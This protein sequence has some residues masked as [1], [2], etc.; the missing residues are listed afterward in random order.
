MIIWGVVVVAF[1]FNPRAR[2]ERDT[3]EGE[4]SVSCDVSIHALAWS[5]TWEKPRYSG[6][7]YVSIHALAWS[8]T[9]S[10][11]I[12]EQAAKVSIHALAWSATKE[13]PFNGTK[14]DVSIHA[15]AWSATV[16][17]CVPISFVMFQ[18]TR[19]HGAR[20]G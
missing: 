13:N 2:M 18:S 7:K 17:A 14:I 4:V 11:Y 15:L 6:R 16:V 12:G 5:A 10:V 1:S 20:L 8:A 3:Y 9:L 19:S